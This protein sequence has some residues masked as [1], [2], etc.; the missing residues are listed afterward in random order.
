MADVT[1]ARLRAL[2]SNIAR[3]RKLLASPLSEL[4]REFIERRLN[5]ETASAEALFPFSL[6]LSHGA[7]QESR[8]ESRHV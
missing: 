3:Y 2:R 7:G 1:L 8:H 4:E 5:E 6:S